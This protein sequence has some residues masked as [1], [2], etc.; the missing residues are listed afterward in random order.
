[1]LKVS[2][3]RKGFL[4]PTGE[5]IEVL[6]DVCFSATPGQ[7]VAIIGASGAGKSTL[8]NLL[9][10]LEVSDGG[11]IEFSQLV[12]GDYSAGGSLFRE[13]VSFVFQFHHLLQDLTA[14]ENVA[15]PLMIARTDRRE[16]LRR[17]TQ[18]LEEIGLMDRATQRIGY[19]SGGEQ[20]RVAVAR[21]LITEPQ[22][23]LADEPTG[24]LDAPIA[25]GIGELL[26]SYSR[27][28]GAIVIVATHN[29]RLAEI[30]DRTLL[31]ENGSIHALN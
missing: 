29:D 7:I 2:N 22:L 10:G 9:G 23:V 16:S 21:A 30:C 31:L 18:A 14:A 28:K 20:Q 5:R 8:L 3:L 1:M 15:L 25:K 13:R 26:A 12:A 4:S 11:R 19:L 27:Q 17:V 24:N 6:R